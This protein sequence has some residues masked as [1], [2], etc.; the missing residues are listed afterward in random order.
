MVEVR[1]AG[2]DTLEFHKVTAQSQKSL[3]YFYFLRKLSSPCCQ[4]DGESSVTVNRKG[5]C[6]LNEIKHIVSSE[7]K[8]MHL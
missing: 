7:S 4:R 2:G 3:S 6:N 5:Y 8:H 1:K